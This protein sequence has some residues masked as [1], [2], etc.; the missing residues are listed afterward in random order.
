MFHSFFNLIPRLRYLSFFHFLSILLCDQSGQ[1]SPQF[2]KFSFFLLIIIRSGCLAENRFYLKIPEEF[3]R[4][5]FQDRCWLCIYR[6][7]VW[8]NFNFLHNSQWV[9]LPTQS[10][11][12]LYYFCANWLH[13][14]K[15]RLIVSSLYL[16]NLHRLFCYVLS[17]LALIWLILIEFFGAAIR[18]NSVSLLKCPF[19]SQ[20][21]VFSCEM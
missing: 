18:S 4:L 20:I 13:S 10:C 21:D 17:I 19:L 7:F 8:S 6:F 3:L 9:T 5:I 14:L 12:A 11:L 2:Y 1:K 15:V 16:Y